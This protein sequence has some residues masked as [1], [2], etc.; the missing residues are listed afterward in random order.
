M[1][2]GLLINVNRKQF[3]PTLCHATLRTRQHRKTL[4]FRGKK[5]YNR[6]LR[7]ASRA[8]SYK[9]QIGK[10]HKQTKK[11]KTTK[12]EKKER[13]KGFLCY[14]KLSRVHMYNSHPETYGRGTAF[15]GHYHNLHI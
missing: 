9:K 3:Q 14:N 4:R 10:T 12:T 7:V 8:I 5:I 11:E 6:S 1:R 2:A 15:F 13:N